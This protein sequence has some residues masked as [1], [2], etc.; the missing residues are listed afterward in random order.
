MKTDIFAMG[1]MRLDIFRL[2]AMSYDFKLAVDVVVRFIRRKFIGF[3]HIFCQQS[4]VRLCVH[5]IKVSCF[6]GRYGDVF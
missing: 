3:C 6:V 4:V 5:F 1:S 2:L